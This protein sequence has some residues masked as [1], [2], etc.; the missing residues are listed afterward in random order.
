MIK[1]ADLERRTPAGLQASTACHVQPSH[2]QHAQ[3]STI[4][5]CACMP[6]SAPAQCHAC[7]LR[8]PATLAP[9]T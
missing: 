2:V 6:H 5:L 1:D 9:H 4:T 3:L 8:R 7:L